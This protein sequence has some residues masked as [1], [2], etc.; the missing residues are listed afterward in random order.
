MIPAKEIMTAVRFQVG[1]MQGAERSDFEIVEA[2]NRAQA[3]IYAA[4]GERHISVGLKT[5]TVEI[6]DDQLWT[7][8]P[9]D[10]HNLCKVDMIHR[11]PGY[12]RV[13]W[14]IEGNH[15]VG[16]AGVYSLSYY[17]LPPRISDSSDLLDIPNSVRL[18]LEGTSAAFLSGNAEEAAA[19]TKRLC[20]VL[21][22]REYD[23]Y[24]D[25]GPVQVWG[26]RA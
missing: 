7:V 24:Q 21:V 17:Y 11:Q 10:F 9:S 2:I 23:G 6:E 26:D 19:I 22:A 8:L 4:F 14:K 3:F 25:H 13:K 20:D 15:F 1:D 18:G 16:I 5:A 12:I